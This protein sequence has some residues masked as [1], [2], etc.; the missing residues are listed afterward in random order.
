MHV[1]IDTKIYKKLNLDLFLRK[2]IYTYVYI[3]IYIYIRAYIWIHLSCDWMSLGIFHIYI[4][5]NLHM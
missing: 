1:F 4:H 2:N 5:I 3:Y